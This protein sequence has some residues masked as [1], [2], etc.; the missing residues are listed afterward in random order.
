[1]EHTRRIDNQLYSRKALN[2]SREAYSK[3][4][5]VRVQPAHDGLADVT[6]SVR[7]AYKSEARKVILE[8]W[9][10]FLDSTIQQHMDAE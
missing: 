10:F 2:A 9:N 7:E 4:C 3:Y 1:M 5:L 8:F 6:I